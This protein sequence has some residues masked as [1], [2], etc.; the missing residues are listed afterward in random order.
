MYRPPDCNWFDRMIQWFYR[1]ALQRICH[2]IILLL[3]TSYISPLAAKDT[4]ISKQ[5]SPSEA[6]FSSSQTQLVQLDVSELSAA[7]NTLSRQFSTPIVYRP[8]DVKGLYGSAIQSEVSLAEALEILLADTSLDFTLAPQGVWL[9]LSEPEESPVDVI[10]EVVVEGFRGTLN[11]ARQLKKDDI[12]IGD[13]IV[14]DDIARFPDLNLAEA[15]QRIPSIAITREAGEGRRIALRGLSPDF[16]LV[17][18]NG[19]DVLGNTDSPMDSRGQKSRDRAFDFNLFPSELFSQITVEKSKAANQQEGGIAGTV[20]LETPK[21]FDRPGMHGFINFQS[22]YNDYSQ[23]VAPRLA[24]LISSTGEN[25]GGLFTLAFSQ[26]E[27]EEQGANTT[28]WRRQG[29]GGA[30]LSSLD[31]AIAE[32]WEEGRLRIPRGN[33]YSVWQ[34]DQTRLG[35]SGS[36][37]YVS[38][39]FDWT[40]D[41]LFSRLKND[42]DEYHLYPRGWQ[43]TPV[44]PADESGQSI[45]RVTE[46]QLDGDRLVFGVYRDAQMA[47]ESRAQ[48]ATTD[49]HQISSRVTWDVNDGLMISGLFGWALS[50][51]SMPQSDK[52]YLEGIS[53]VSI[54]YR[55]DPFYG[56]YQYSA[57]TR[58]PGSWYFHEV[59]LEEYYAESEYTTGQLDL[60]QE[61]STS[62]TLKT[63][64][65]YKQL[66]NRTARGNLDNLL[67]NEWALSRGDAVNPSI[68]DIDSGLVPGVYRVMQDH[69]RAHWLVVDVD[70][71]L[72]YFGLE[73]S[74][75]FTAADGRG[76]GIEDSRDGIREATLASYIQLDWRT[77]VLGFPAEGNIG[78]R[79]YHTRT[80]S[81]TLLID[82]LNTVEYQYQGWLPSVNIVLSPSR[83]W[84]LRAGLYQNITRPDLAALSRSLSIREDADEI[85]IVAPNRDLKPYR[86]NNIDVAIEYYFDDEGYFA[87]NGFSK[88]IS[89]FI[90]TRR[91]T[92]VASELEW[93]IPSSVLAGD[94]LVTQVTLA[95]TE[96]AKI[97]GVELVLQKPFTFF[98]EPLNKAGIMLNLAYSEGDINYYSESTGEFLFNKPVPNLS[99]R[100]RGITLY[101]E[102]ARWGMRLSSSYRSRF[103]SEVDTD[104]LQDE[105]ERGFHGTTHYDFSSYFKLTDSLKL[106]FEGI[107]LTDER[108]EQYSDS[109][110]LAY[111]TT[112]SGATFFIGLQYNW[113]SL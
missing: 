15:L 83:R 60:A 32:S 10:T 111:N 2:W 33:R 42:R 55:H 93:M 88:R 85:H 67:R 35:L 58:N 70:S 107:N 61:I 90:V 24:G 84:R 103:I 3:V 78:I 62:A 1:L 25:W 13:A 22:G 20:S 11:T 44:I 64:L 76:L 95:N 69:H 38:D 26:R 96:T 50:E 39:S 92:L 75:V 36:L 12:Q 9:S 79:Y 28:R 65:S 4:L 99:R 104:V 16:T 5:L 102:L 43:S 108:E 81:D 30:D 89:D 56:D 105:N 77:E 101:Y 47:T 82:D 53:D 29:A 71:V 48:Q 72:R 7:L 45:T 40:T 109:S 110:D 18:L 91:D 21:P 17:Q 19:M 37:Q 98:P 41:A 51:F 46:A 6:S 74:S 86:S 23:T 57:D 66:K 52:V 27:T 49:F 63:G 87:V 100:T 112:S 34:S 14:A 94:Q 73:D 31:P 113:N 97:H 80:K 8:A 59:D 54:D 68:S 106:T